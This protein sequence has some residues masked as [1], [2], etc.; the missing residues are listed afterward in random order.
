MDNN[1][2]NYAG[3]QPEAANIA[4]DYQGHQFGNIF[5]IGD[6]AGLASGLTGEGILPAII[7]GEEIAKLIIN[8]GYASNKLTNLIKN[9]SLHTRIL[10]LSGKSTFHC[11]TIMESLVLALRLKLV[12]FSALEMGH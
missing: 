11:R 10:L 6:A 2:I 4:F 8:P 9:H 1:E 7:S 5:L 3:L 12:P